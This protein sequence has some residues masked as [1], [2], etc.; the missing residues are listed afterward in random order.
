MR[1]ANYELD[2]YYTSEVSDCVWEKLD[3]LLR[4]PIVAAS[5]DSQ[6]FSVQSI[7]YADMNKICYIDID[8]TY[9]TINNQDVLPYESFDAQT[10]MNGD[11]FR[12]QLH[13]FGNNN[14]KRSMCIK[15]LIKVGA[16]IESI[17]GLCPVECHAETEPEV[18]LQGTCMPVRTDVSCGVRTKLFH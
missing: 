6:L 11:T 2:L 14:L 10:C 3:G 4:V 15:H 16:T 18:Q 13:R 12:C 5:G 1:I 9:V 8:T 17:Q 7:P